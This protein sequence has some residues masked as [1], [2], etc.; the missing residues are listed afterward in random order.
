[1]GKSALLRQLQATVPGAVTLTCTA[2]T[3]VEAV[4][5]AVAHGP[6]LVLLDDVQTLVKPVQG[7]LKPFDAVLAFAQEHSQ[8]SLWVFALDGVVWP[9]LR[10][11]RDARPLFDE[12]LALEAWTDEEIGEL[13]LGRSA[14]AGLAPT[15]EDLL[16]KLPAS[17]DEID[18]QEALLA[19][20]AGYFRVVWDYARGNPGLALEVW[21]ASL[22][23]DAAGVARVRP[24]QAPA[25][26][27]LES[28]PDDTLFI[29]RSVLQ[30]AARAGRRRGPRDQA[31]PR[32]R[33]RTRCASR[34]R[35]ATWSRT[36]A[37]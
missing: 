24:L 29:L 3:S 23:A 13:L 18:W 30:M 5:A 34:R 14:E 4:R 25:A 32:P 20:R 28:L 26:D 9:F 37:G 35:T 31:S 17:A 2:S 27:A 33:C 22:S 16:E 1:M 11:A 6:Q 21:R 10:R 12:V 19:Q 36:R 7:G 8:Q 15:F